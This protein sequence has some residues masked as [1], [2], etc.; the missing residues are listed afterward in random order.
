MISFK[1]IS[2]YR[3]LF[4]HQILILLI[5]DCV[6]L[7]LPSWVFVFV[8]NNTSTSSLC[9]LTSEKEEDCAVCVVLILE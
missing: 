2:T 1:P 7:E 6:C 5:V 8:L 9:V 3:I 4:K